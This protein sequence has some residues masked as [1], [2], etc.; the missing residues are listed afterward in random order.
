MKRMMCFLGTIATACSLNA[1]A[2]DLPAAKQLDSGD[3]LMTQLLSN[4]R[5]DFSRQFRDLAEH[6]F[7]KG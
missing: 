2:S 7:V 4:I 5:P 6:N 1:L 3:Q